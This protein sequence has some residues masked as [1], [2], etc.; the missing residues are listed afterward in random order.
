[1]VT[2]EDWQVDSNDLR[3]LGG[4]RNIWLVEAS[5]CALKMSSG[6]CSAIAIECAEGA[7]VGWSPLMLGAGREIDHHAL[8]GLLWSVLDTNTWAIRLNTWRQTLT[9]IACA[10]PLTNLSSQLPTAHSAAWIGHHLKQV[11]LNTGDDEHYLIEMDSDALPLKVWPLPEGTIAWQFDGVVPTKVSAVPEWLNPRSSIRVEASEGAFSSAVFD[12]W[13]LGWRR[14]F[15][16]SLGLPA[17]TPV[18]SQAGLPPDAVTHPLMSEWICRAVA[19]RMDARPML[20]NRLRV[21]SMPTRLPGILPEH[22][23]GWWSAW[24]GDGMANSIA[25]A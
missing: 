8:P 6:G 17:D 14:A 25:T 2:H 12:G 10:Q 20:R 3:A 23:S 4:I 9:S 15:V 24:R 7:L 22:L 5:A 21:M 19:C 11:E 13:P 18:N 1:M 16:S